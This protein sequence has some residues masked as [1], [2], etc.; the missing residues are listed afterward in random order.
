M[1]GPI[2]WDILLQSTAVSYMIPEWGLHSRT[3]LWIAPLRI[4]TLAVFHVLCRQTVLETQ[5]NSRSRHRLGGFLNYCHFLYH[6]MD[7]VLVSLV[8][9]VLYFW[10]REKKFLL[11][12]FLLPIIFEESPPVIIT[13]AHDEDIIS[14]PHL[15]RNLL[16]QFF[17]DTLEY[18]NC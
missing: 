15:F 17:R 6:M 9:Q 14:L 3:S 2:Q 1:D 7:S 16:Q 13:F 5:I 10:P 12:T 4:N 11:N 18:L 8:H